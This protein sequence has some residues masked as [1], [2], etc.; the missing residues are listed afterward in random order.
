MRHRVVSIDEEQ[1][2]ARWR[3]W[4]SHGRDGERR[5]M[6]TLGAVFVVLAVALTVWAF[7]RLV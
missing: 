7:M 6:R 5:R 1:S 2:N 4:Q 3:D